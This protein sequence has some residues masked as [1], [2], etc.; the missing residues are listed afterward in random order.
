MA[1]IVVIGAGIG[2]LTAGLLL[3]AAGH[4]VTICEAAAMPGGKLRAVEVGGVMIDA[5]PTVL[6]LLPVF[7]SI[8]TQ[9]G[10]RLEDHLTFEKLDVLA[11]HVWAPGESLDLFSDPARSA[12]AIG[13]LA[14]P[15]AARGFETFAARAAE[16][17]TILDRSFMAA[18]QPGLFGLMARGGPGLLKISPFATLWDELRRY[19][20]D[21]RLRQLF[22]R[23]ATYCGASPFTAPATLLL[24]A[25]AEQRGV[26]RIK[27][28]MHRLAAA[29]AALAE[30][31]G[32]RL[33]LSAPVA[34][35]TARGGRADGVR[36]ADGEVIGADAVIANAD[37]AALSDGLFGAA[38]QAAVAGMLSG[39]ARSLS[40]RTWAITGTASGFAPAHHNVVFS[41]D[42]AAE[43]AAIEAGHVLRDP[44]VYVCAPAPGA[45][46]CLVNETAR[47]DAA[48]NDEERDSECLD[49]M[50]E[51]LA[52]SGLTL[53]PERIK[54]TGPAQFARLFPATGG[55]LYG[56]ALRSWRDPFARPG[57]A[58][59]LPGLYLAGG[60][61]HPGPGLPMAALSGRQAAA[62]VMRDLASTSRSS[63]AAT[64]GG[65]STR[66]RMTARRR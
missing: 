61:A 29:M 47:G 48:G 51:K 6:T 49:R 33:R 64:P 54:A 15:A 55:A 22:G 66:F 41:K 58:T 9:A 52:R 63:R 11:R 40:A 20:D 17:F 37:L 34:E 39:A 13:E 31:R 50:L 16:V 23:Y 57:A 42:Y 56:R 5:G 18:P 3:T 46:F 28:G 36:L 59:R 32:A 26:W 45:F 14:G 44:T 25:H 4:D 8:F 38:A 62:A 2:G 65:M 19:F 30:A 43:F 35:I 21:P 12:A 24:I 27:E 10:A 7:E 1:R 53:T 60:S